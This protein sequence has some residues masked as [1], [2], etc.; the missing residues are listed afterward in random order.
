MWCGLAQNGLTLAKV[1]AV[2]LMLVVVYAAMIGPSFR[3]RSALDRIAKS[4][5]AVAPMSCS[6]ALGV[7]DLSLVVIVAGLATAPYLHF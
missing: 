7:F 6:V 5:R 3:G 4:G 1:P 2:V